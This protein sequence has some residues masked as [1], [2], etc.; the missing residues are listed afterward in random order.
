MNEKELFDV[1]KR[2]KGRPLT[3]ADVDAVNRVLRGESLGLSVSQQ[4]IDLI[5]SF[6]Q[7]RL[8]AYPDPGSRNGLPWTIGW[9]STGPDVVRGTVWTKEKADQRFADDLEK[10]SN[11]VRDL[12]GTV[13]QNQ[14]D[15]MVSLA[16][17]IGLTAFAKSTLLKKH[18]AGDYAGAQRAFASWIYN[19]GKVMRGLVRRR[20]QE[21]ALYGAK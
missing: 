14:L 4:G 6:E 2:I 21:A 19:D 16:Y 11:G 13:T 9:G 8:V 20:S 10:F 7:L 5:H 12:V 18:L 17:N 1:I 3:Q 15:A